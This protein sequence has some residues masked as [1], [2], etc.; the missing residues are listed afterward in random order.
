M[1]SVNALVAALALACLTPGANAIYEDQAGLLDW[2]TEHLGRVSAVAFG[3]GDKRHHAS[4]V[5]GTSRA[6]YVATDERSRAIARLDAKNGAIKWRQVLHEG[7]SIDTIQL[8]NHGLLTVS[9]AAKNLRLWD[10]ADGTLA[11][12]NVAYAGVK[13]T[14]FAGIHTIADDRS[15]VVSSTGAALVHLK[16]G[17]VSW[18]AEFPSPLTGDVISS[19][20]SSDAS[21]L[22]VLA[23][24]QLLKVDVKTGKVTKVAKETL[25]ANSVLRKHGTSGAVVA[26]TV[27]K[28]DVLV[29]SLE[30][31]DASKSI[32][33]ADAKLDAAKAFDAVNDKIKSALVV[34]L[35]SGE[36]VYFKITD[37]LALEV[38][39]KLSGEDVLIESLTDDNVLF[40]IASKSSGAQ[41][42]SYSLVPDQSRAQWEMNLDVASFGG[43]VGNAFVGCPVRQKDTGAPRCRALLVM[44]DDGLIFSTNEE[45]NDAET[46]TSSNAP[47]WVREESLANVKTVHW[48]TPAETDIEKQPLKKIPSFSEEITMEIA[49]AKQFANNVLSFFNG[50]SA[51]EDR[52]R[53]ETPNAHLF[54]FSKYIVALTESGKLFA[55]RAELSTVAWSQFVGP[56]YKLFVTRDHPAMGSGP[57]L[58][59]VSS[60][61]HLLWIDGDDGHQIESINADTDGE[62]SWVVVLPKREHHIDEDANLRRAVALVSEKTLAVSLYP[63]ETAGF[64]HP[65]LDNFYFY[66]YDAGANVLRGYVIENEGDASKKASYRAQEVWSVV[67]PRDH[68]LAAFSSQKEHTVIDSSV[69]VTGDDSLLL[70]YLNPNLF[71]V[72]TTGSE[73]VEGESAP[74][75]VLQVSLLDSVAGRL[76]HRARHQHASG[77]VRMVQ[78]ENWLVYSF[79]N[80]KDKRTEVVSLSLYDGAVGANNLNPWKRPTWSESRSSFDPRAPFVLQKS[81]IFPTTIESLGVSVTS[82]GITPQCVL[83]GMGTG[84]IFKLARNFIDPRQT[85]K[86]PSPEEQEEGLMQYSP[87]ISVYNRPF[88]MITYNQTVANIKVITTAPAELESTTLVFAHG[89]DHFYVRLA[90]AKAFDLLPS[91]FN[92][93]MLILLCIGFIVATVLSRGLARRKALNEAWK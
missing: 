86:P 74:V 21:T 58:L 47:L 11:W 40:H 25:E 46:V 31:G 80:A 84:Q 61:S 30:N 49:R 73:Q 68:K 10:A 57:E 1:K 26:V 72:A 81:F 76:I 63:A 92:Y 89:L 56:E 83:V 4:V 34:T 75:S 13:E 82:H 70:K 77:L 48:V 59:L 44:K 16:D 19:E 18:R 62:K 60:S 52:S 6:V 3:G 55:I 67:L 66:R 79:W 54:G 17:G 41:V 35:V 29:E 87:L 33:I 23:D 2:K 14:K 38:V 12:D 9:G 36:N 27:S 51:S 22:F 91:D 7:D 71:A 39:A 93:E 64:A 42:S 5:R 45:S 15:V 43:A 32:S 53:K 69:T 78:S 50:K 88:S 8:T 90:P 20:L 85:E 24:A 28:T 37:S 65:E